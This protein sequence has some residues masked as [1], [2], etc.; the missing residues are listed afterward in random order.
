M[1]KTTHYINL[2]QETA[3]RIEQDR[4]DHVLNPYATR[5]ED[6]IR[7]DPAHDIANLH[8]PAFVRD[9]EK[10][11]NVPYYNRYSDKTQVFSLVRNDDISRRALHVQFVSRIARN[12]GRLLNLNMDLIEA[13]ALGHDIGHTPFGHAG[14]HALSDIYY[15]HTGRYFNHNVHSVRVL[16]DICCQNLSLQTLDGIICHNGEKELK[17]YRPRSDGRDFSYFDLMKEGCYKDKQEVKRLIPCTLEGCVVRV[18]DII[19]YIGKD[20][21]D[22][23]KLGI[24]DDVQAPVYTQEKIGTTNAEIINNIIVN[25]VENS[26]GKPYLKMDEEYF[27]EFTTAK[28]E[29]Q[30]HIYDNEKTEAA[31]KSDIEPMFRELY[32][33]LL[34]QAKSMDPDSVLVR[35]HVDYIER[36]T[37]YVHV[38]HK[39]YRETAPDDMVTDYIASMTDDYFIDLYAFLFPESEHRVKYRGYFG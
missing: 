36:I 19:A 8:R 15:A 31:F 5:D 39:D 17:E 18:S 22:A 10:I 9:I 26:Y 7:R 37:K 3:E 11:M 24:F 28:T 35:H 29:N 33:E 6:I 21:Q 27:K 38:E 16:D 14:E 34:S 20:R 25:I 4:K 23:E 2:S 1:N 32:E 13:I 12:I 30:K